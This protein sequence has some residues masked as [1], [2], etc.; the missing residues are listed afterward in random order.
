LFFVTALRPTPQA[1]CFP[2]K[3]TSKQ[4]CTFICRMLN[5]NSTFSCTESL[6][7]LFLLQSTV[8]CFAFSQRSPMFLKIRSLLK[9][10]LYWC[11]DSFN[12]SLCISTFFQFMCLDALDWLPKKTRKCGCGVR[13]LIK[14]SLKS[15]IHCAKLLPQMSCFNILLWGAIFPQSLHFLLQPKT[16]PPP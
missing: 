3:V 4:C 14:C 13:K 16:F 11:T 2:F 7:N 12:C 1:K 9:S 15:Q 5:L 6:L 10:I 8:G